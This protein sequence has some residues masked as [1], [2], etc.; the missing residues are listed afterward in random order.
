MISSNLTKVLE[1]LGSLDAKT[2]GTSFSDFLKQKKAEN[3]IML[4]VYDFA[5]Y[6][7]ALLLEQDS[8]ILWFVT[9]LPNSC[10]RSAIVGELW[11]EQI[12]KP[13]ALTMLKKEIK[14][15]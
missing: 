14:N 1:G 15:I 13:L 5:E 11:L 9:E 6:R 2:H 10:V 3:T 12:A 8:G 4:L 7:R